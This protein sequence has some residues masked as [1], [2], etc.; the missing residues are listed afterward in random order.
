MLLVDDL[1]C[2]EKWSR[3]LHLCYYPSNYM[4][5]VAQANKTCSIFHLNNSRLMYVKNP[6]EIFY[7]AH[8]LNT[9]NLNKLL[10]EIDPDLMKGN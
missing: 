1:S 10:L 9:N 5:T 7:A 6:L 2:P 3:F 4:S 8:V